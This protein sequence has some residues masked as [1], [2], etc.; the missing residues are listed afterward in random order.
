MYRENKTRSLMIHDQESKSTSSESVQLGS[1]FL[2]AN[3][4]FMA[5]ETPKMVK[6]PSLP[7]IP[8]KPPIP[9]SM[10]EI[11]EDSNQ[12]VREKPGSLVIPVNPPIHI[13]AT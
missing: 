11:K 6:M 9:K 7:P 3:H 13:G 1:G 5:I 2:S 12:E 4:A 8:S 10:E